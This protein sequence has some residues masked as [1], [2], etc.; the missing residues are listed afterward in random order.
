VEEVEVE[1]AAEVVEEGVEVEAAEVEG[2]VE[3]AVEAI[4]SPALIK[5]RSNSMRHHV[6]SFN[7]IRLFLG[8]VGTFQAFVMFANIQQSISPQIN[9]LVRNN[10]MILLLC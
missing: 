4:K 6:A 2:V 3:V 7:L 10:I 8:N 9:R 5:T 1:A